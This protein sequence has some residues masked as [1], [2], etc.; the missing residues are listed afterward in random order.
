MKILEVAAFLAIPVVAGFIV[1][2]VTKKKPKV[3]LLIWAFIM[4]YMLSGLIFSLVLVTKQETPLFT[5]NQMSNEIFVIVT[6]G[7]LVSGV[8]YFFKNKKNLIKHFFK[9]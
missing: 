6:G 2:I 9:E 8:Y 1:S 7:F 5:R 4:I 3:Q